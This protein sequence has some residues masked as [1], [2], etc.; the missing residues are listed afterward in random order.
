MDPSMTVCVQWIEADGRLIREQVGPLG[1]HCR[2]MVYCMMP[3]T[4]MMACTDILL[5]LSQLQC[6]KDNSVQP[7]EAME[8]SRRKFK[9]TR[10][11]CTDAQTESETHSGKGFSTPGTRGPRSRKSNFC[12][13]SSP[14]RFRMTMHSWVAMISLCLSKRPCMPTAASGGQRVQAR[15][16]GHALLHAW[17]S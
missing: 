7:G 2:L 4:V 10:R 17:P 5:C 8:A 11:A 16:F 3:V 14:L 6:L 1:F 9:R 15:V 13:C 12:C